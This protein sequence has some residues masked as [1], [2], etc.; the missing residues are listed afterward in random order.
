MTGQIKILFINP[1]GTDVY[2]DHMEQVLKEKKNSE[3]ELHVRHL[4]GVI[5]TPTLPN[6]AMFYNQLFQTIMNAEKEDF[7]GI[8]IGCADDPGLAEAKNLVQI[9]VTGPFEAAVFTAQA[10]GRFSVM[11]PTIPPE[12]AIKYS[13]PFGLNWI[14]DLAYQY[15]A[16]HTIASI[17]G[18]DT[19][20]QDVE[21]LIKMFQENPK[22]VAQQMLAGMKRLITDNAID[23]AKKA[24]QEEGAKAIF[25]ACTFWGGMLDSLLDVVPIPI[26]DPIITPLK[27]IET[28]A[29]LRNTKK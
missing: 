2:N 4:E 20:H 10:F 12:F 7:D 5:P 18:F 19:G 14:H 13:M 21:A 26:L 11:A 22:Q 15:G 17:H 29:S 27:Y 24:F 1:I 28:L 25:F 9:P 3:T 8:I 6:P 16:T 23:M